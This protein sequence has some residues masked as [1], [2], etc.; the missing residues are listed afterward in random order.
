MSI[1]FFQCRRTKH[2]TRQNATPKSWSEALDLVVK[3]VEHIE[4]GYVR[5][6]AISPGRMSAV[7]LSYVSEQAGL[8]QQNERMFRMTTRSHGRFGGGNLLEAPA[9]V[10]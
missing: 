7:R 9:Q 10:N 5:D 8:C 4:L 3:T 1:H 6:M 2:S